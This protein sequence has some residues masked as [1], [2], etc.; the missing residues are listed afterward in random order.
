MPVSFLELIDTTMN[1]AVNITPNF[2][3]KKEAT[4]M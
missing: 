2:H 4:K 1:E 3:I